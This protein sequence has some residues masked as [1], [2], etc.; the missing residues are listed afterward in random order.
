MEQLNEL[1][2][3]VVNTLD[4]N[5]LLLASAG[6]GKTNTLAHRVA[7]IIQ[8]GAAQGDEI[9]CLTFTNKACREMKDRIIS[10]VSK[11][12]LTSSEA[13]QSKTDEQG[14]TGDLAQGNHVNGTSSPEKSTSMA[15]AARAV[16]VSTFHSFCYK[17]LQ[18]E[19]KL[20]ESL[21][22]DM[23]IY[24]EEDCEELL[25]PLRPMSMKPFAY[26][27]LISF[28]KEYRSLFGYYSDDAAIDY[29]RT[30]D[31][32]SKEKSKELAGFFGVGQLLRQDFEDFLAHGYEQLVAYEQSLNQLHGVDFTDLITGVHRLFQNPVIRDRWRQRYSYICV[33]E[34]QDTSDLE[35][36]VMKELWPGNHILLCGDYFQTIYEW[37]GSNPEAFLTMYEEEFKPEII[38]FYEN[39][40]ANRH[41]FDASF[42]VLSHMF[43]NLLAKFYKQKPYAA[44]TEVGEPIIV[45]QAPT[46]W[47]E[48]AFIFDTIRS[49]PKDASIGVLVRVNKQAQNFS[50]FFENLNM[51]LEPE[52]RRDF[53]I[54]DEFKFFRRQEIKDVMAYFKLLLNPNDALS[55]K[56]LV[57]R[58]VAGI[59][60]ARIKELE[61]EAVRTLGLRLTDFLDMQI[62]EHEP[63]DRLITGLKDG[64]VV[65]YDVES[66]GTDTTR[67]EIIQIAAYRMNPDGSEGEIFERFIRPTK[68]VGSSQAVH[69]FTD[70]YLATKGEPAEVVLKDFLEFTKGAII[71]GHNVSYDVNIF[72]SELHRHQ[73]G[74]PQFGA[75]Y[76]TLDM[77]RR[78]YPRLPNHKLGFLS[79]HFPINH[80][81]THNAMDDIRATGLLLGYILKENIVPTIDQRR[82]LIVRYKGAFATIASQMTTLRR[83][84]AMEKPTQLLAYIMNDMGV[85]NYYKGR[86]EV[87]RV[88]HIRDLYR[89]L[90]DLEMT[91]EELGGRDCLQRI[92]EEA[93]LTAGEPDRRIKNS[94]RIPIITIHQAKGSEFD[95]VFLAGMTDNNFPSFYALK[96]GR[97]AEEQRLFYVAL[98]R[99]KK[100]LYISYSKTGGQYNRENT[101]SRFLNY[102]PDD[103]VF[104]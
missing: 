66:T 53:M 12:G 78:F 103:V 91:N 85:I 33:D 14:L 18:A 61:S 60:E 13:G 40:R 20:D 84:S 35:G 89:I 4:K 95:Y 56:R 5:I 64:K 104:D 75:V 2:H 31:R 63:Y 3:Q 26:A 71:V 49:L 19:S 92:L 102:L 21:Y 28:V 65:I 9:L 30:I 36:L 11:A 46:E 97:L 41:L 90:L 55:V 44:S 59:G 27:G 73:L 82:A 6:T 48:G 43:P 100:K 94:S 96:E 69:G 68:S 34:M 24:D 8:S 15:E 47:K 77:F 16:E 57:K 70:E 10:I 98:T 23:A 1:Q 72:T 74:R 39:Y 38:V 101:P 76:D 17:I 81:P 54:I 45:H 51:K 50:H 80:K 29:K 52:E 93:A 42:T 22:A 79:E 67:D 58:Y 83:K 99:A 86:N 87:E 25:T 88:E 32:L 7:H 62:F 37:R